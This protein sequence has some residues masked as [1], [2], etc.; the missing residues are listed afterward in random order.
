MKKCTLLLTVLVS[1]IAASNSYAADSFARYEMVFDPTPKSSADNPTPGIYD[2]NFKGRLYDM[3]GSE[4]HG[5]VH[6]PKFTTGFSLG[7]D[8]A[9]WFNGKDDYLTMPAEDYTP[10]AADQPFMISFWEKTCGTGAKV[11]LTLGK[12]SDKAIIFSFDSNGYGSQVTINGRTY[13][14]GAVGD[15][16]DG[17]YHHVMLRH[18]GNKVE[19]YIDANRKWSKTIAGAIGIRSSFRVSGDVNPW[20]GAIDN[21]GFYDY[22]GFKDIDAENVATRTFM[23][24][25]LLQGK[26]IVKGPWELMTCDAAFIRRDGPGALV[27][28]NKMWFL[29]GWNP[30]FADGHYMLDGVDYGKPENKKKF[31]GQDGD[32]KEI[33]TSTDGKNWDFVKY[34]PW[35]Q[36]HMAGWTVFKNKMWIIGGDSNNNV[37]Q[38]DTWSSVDGNRWVNE[39]QR[40]ESTNAGTEGWTGQ[41]PGRILHHVQVFKDKIWVMG[42]QL[43]TSSN[44]GTIFNDVWNSADGIKWKRVTE[45]ADWSPRGVITG[46]AVFKDEM[47]IVAGGSY[48]NEYLNEVWHSAD[49]I[50]WAQVAQPNPPYFTERY[51]SDI[52][53][54]DNK[55]WLT[56]GVDPAGN[57]NEVFFTED[58]VHWT[59]VANTDWGPRHG[60]AVWVYQNALYVGAGN[61]WND[62]WK[63]TPESLRSLKTFYRDRD[64]DGFG[65]RNYPVLANEPSVATTNPL[66]RFVT[67]DNDCDD[68]NTDMHPANPEDPDSVDTCS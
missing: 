46:S 4:R 30:S 20:Y 26:P 42:G 52:H 16:T 2:Y 22:D 61:L 27:F 11:A 57:I 66:K 33:W 31:P 3:S 56:G 17:R 43:D 18:A 36:R 49:G 21:V 48:G 39:T 7:G 67:S 14:T 13:S 1:A 23:I 29:G 60:N 51:Y 44:P 64:N 65:D 47:W 68:S 32:S 8:G 9:Y 6:G 38:D 28:K 40:V 54:F 25:S 62:V 55:L 53:V 34:A 59:E 12:E 63:L 37:R 41:W 35:Q 15:F 5:E 19:L 50:N 45:H 10:F 24:E 58:G